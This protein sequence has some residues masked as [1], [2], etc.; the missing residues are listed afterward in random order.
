MLLRLRNVVGVVLGIMLLFVASSAL[1]QSQ[2][3]SF[4]TG[5]GTLMYTAS[6]D[7]EPCNGEGGLEATYTDWTFASFS[8]LSAQ[9]TTQSIGGFTT[10]V[11]SPFAKATGSCPANTAGR[12]ITFNGSGY[13]MT[14]VPQAGTVNATISMSGYINPKYVVVGVIY[15][16]PGSK[17]FVTYTNSK[18]I[19]STSAVTD[20]FI[21]SFTQTVKV[22]QP[23]GLFGFLGGSQTTTNSTT[24]T[25][26]SQNSNSV[27]ASETTTS[28]LQLFGPGPSNNC[29]SNAGDFI[30]VDHDCDQIRVWINP[31]MLFTLTNNGEDSP[32]VQWNGYG[33]S[34]LDTTAP[35]DIVDI[36]GAV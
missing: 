18:T 12:T 7:T 4:G 15:A 29:G 24:L 20:T 19:S 34:A 35:V 22:T 33:F 36:L 25:Q 8:Y 31:A 32:V 13:S 10:Y 28:G 5:L 17:S 6:G 30:G 14:I 2:T 9:N 26:Q 27:T 23:G 3:Y 11:E 16:P 21:S 1:A